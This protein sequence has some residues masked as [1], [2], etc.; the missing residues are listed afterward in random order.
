MG[1]FLRAMHAKTGL[2]APIPQPACGGLPV[3]PL[4]SLALPKN[5][6]HAI[7]GLYV[8]ASQKRMRLSQ[9]ASMPAGCILTNM[10]PHSASD[11]PDIEQMR[12]GFNRGS[13]RAG[14]SL[15]ETPGNKAVACI[16]G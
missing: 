13:A 4:L 14:V 16:L 3:F 5:G 9:P 11:S 8:F 1:A 10:E 15:R 7:F 6:I 2:S 12:P